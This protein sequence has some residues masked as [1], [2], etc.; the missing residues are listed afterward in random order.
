MA[1][2]SLKDPWGNYQ[3]GLVSLA[4]TVTPSG[5]G[6]GSTSSGTADPNTLGLSSSILSYDLHDA[7]TGAYISTYYL[8]PVSGLYE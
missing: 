2:I 7:T 4:S 6:G 3:P 5:G 1:V 8:N